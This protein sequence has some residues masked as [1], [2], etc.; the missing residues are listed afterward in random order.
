MLFFCLTA[1]FFFFKINFFEKDFRVYLLSVKQFGI[2]SGP[3]FCRPSS[4]S[5]LFAQKLSADLMTLAGKEL[6]FHAFFRLTADFFSESTFLN[7]IFGY[8]FRVSNSLDSDQARHS[9]GPDLVP[10][11]LPK[12]YQQI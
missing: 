3:T 4:V 2:R 1:D 11:C 9:V 5:K 7:K 8:T 12:R 10:I 6:I